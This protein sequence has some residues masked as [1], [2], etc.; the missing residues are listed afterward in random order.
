LPGAAAL[1]MDEDERKAGP[2]AAYVAIR[3]ASATL[4]AWIN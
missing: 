3:K 1:A 4:V 2:L